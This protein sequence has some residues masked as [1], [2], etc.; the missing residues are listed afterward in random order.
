MKNRLEVMPRGYSLQELD[1]CGVIERQPHVA[2][3]TPL[4]FEPGDVDG[5]LRA[6]SVVRDPEAIDVRYDGLDGSLPYVLALTYAADRRH[7]RVQSLHSRDI[8]IHGP[9]FLHQGRAERFLVCVPREAIRD[10]RLDLQVRREGE[11]DAVLGSIELWAPAPESPTLRI[12]QVES[13]FGDL[14]GEVTDIRFNRVAGARVFLEGSV[15]SAATESGPDARFSVSREVVRRIAAGSGVRI[16]ATWQDRTGVL[17]LSADELSFA[18]VR[19][20]PMPAA[21]AG[22]DSPVVRLDGAWSVNPCPGE[23]FLSEDI[24]A[25]GKFTVPG[26]FAQQGYDV[27]DDQPLAVAHEFEIPKEWDGYRVILR[28]DSI[29]AGTRY[30]LNGT[31]LG[32]SE[33]LFTPVEWEIT[34]C[35]RIGNTNRLDLLMIVGTT[36]ERISFSSGYAFHNLG[37]ID[38]KVQLFALPKACVRDLR[39]WTVLDRSYRDASLNLAFTLESHA[40]ASGEDFQVNLSLT[41]PQGEPVEVALPEARLNVA[42]GTSKAF[43]VSANVVNPLKWSAEKPFLYRLHFELR[44]GGKAVERIERDIGFREV[45]VRGSQLHLNGRRIKLAGA[46]HH[47]LHPLTGR[48]DTA[49]WAERD[50]TLMKGG[51]LNYLRTSHYP[52]TEELLEAADRL[53]MYVE[54]EA[55]LCWV[56]EKERDVPL[57]EVLT[58]TSA[59]IDFCHAHPS[60]ILWSLANESNFKQFF[61][62]AN[63]LCKELDPT[64]PTTFNDPDPER[65]CDIAN[66]HY[67]PMPYD[68]QLEGDPRPI[69]LGEYFFPL[70]HEQTDM[71]VDPGLR[72]LWGHG[73]ADPDSAWGRFCASSVDR[74]VGV[75]PGALPGTWTHIVRSNRVIGGAIWASHDEPFFLPKGRKAGYAWVHGYWGLLDAWRRPKPE[76]WLAKLIFS[77]VWFPKRVLDFSPGQ[78]SLEIPVENRYAFTDLADLSFS[79]K[80]AGAKGVLHAS[81]PPDSSG[82]LAVPLAVGVQLGCTIDLEVRTATGDLV[83]AA[84]LTLGNAPAAVLPQPGGGTPKWKEEDGRIVVEGRGFGLVF[85]RSTMRCLPADPRHRSAITAFPT[86]HLTRIDLADLVHPRA[87][88]YA[89]LPDPNTRRI[90]GVAVLETAA[91]LEITVRDTYDALR[92]SVSWLIDARGTGRIRSHYEFTGHRL[93]AREVGVRFAMR[94]DCDVL[95]WKRWSEWGVFPGDDISRVEGRAIARRDESLG[96]GGEEVPPHWPW[97]LDQNE[98]GT[99]DFRGIKFCIREASVTASGGSHAGLRVLADADAH[100][101]AC[102]DPESGVTLLHVLSECR[103]GP[104]LL[105]TGDAVRGEFHVEVLGP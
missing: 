5:E 12:L 7:Q 77:P 17:G 6:R 100:V 16:T 66:L 34:E 90:E 31:L 24:T 10:G 4:V 82:T 26:Q 95:A 85:D 98:F 68:A 43:S 42:A 25:W 103:L 96:T 65:V 81:V 49:R 3:K 28:F 13:L 53:G 55:P 87:A 40:A 57:R 62:V 86:V 78:R 59:M 97:A 32:Q 99:N 46:C 102:I 54:C 9:I 79:W 8:E 19:Y 2:Q 44:S 70:C 41:G 48:A 11:G 22:L 14:R 91:G 52:P 1:Q 30:W 39:L 74:S 72:E 18:P 63:R 84:A 50:V 105:G 47:E 73:H 64:R 29:H 88:P 83:T 33:N 37:G 75:F 35:A 93:A 71:R 101:R 61:K 60:I 89:V 27:P 94:A 92:G 80:L 104:V 23:G 56:R 58:P 21:V 51:S 67:P 45:E 69:L 15:G 36:S 76:W 38:R 20:R